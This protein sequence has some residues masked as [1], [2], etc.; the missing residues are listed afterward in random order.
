MAI[1]YPITLPTAQGFFTVS[2]RPFSRVGIFA[3]EF[4]GQQQ[5]YAHAGQF[6]I[7]DIS[8]P[9]MKRSDAAPIIAALQSLQGVRGTFYFGDP[10]WSYPQGVGSGTPTI[11]GATQTGTTLNTTGWTSSQTGILKAGDWIQIGTGSTR[12]LCMVLVDADSDG[13]GQATLELFPRVR[14]AFASGTTIT[15]SNPAGV[16]RLGSEMDFSQVLGGITSLNTI[17]AVEAF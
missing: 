16:W 13:S 8:F 10:A 4:T 14:T 12:Q 9:Q 5:V 2:I 15:A 6:L 11:D 7:C 17:S 3:S 1:S